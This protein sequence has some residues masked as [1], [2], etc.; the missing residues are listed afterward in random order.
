MQ[1][2]ISINSCYEEQ[3]GMPLGG[4]ITYMRA[5]WRLIGEGSGSEHAY[6]GP[7]Q[8]DKPCKL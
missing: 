2:A 7:D 5:Q 6:T 1:T 3:R 8:A 4:F